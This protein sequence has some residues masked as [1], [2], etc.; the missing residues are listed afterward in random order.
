MRINAETSSDMKYFNVQP[1]VITL[2]EYLRKIVNEINKGYGAYV[3]LEKNEDRRFPNLDYRTSQN[4]SIVFET[5][6]NSFIFTMYMSTIINY[7]K[8]KLWIKTNIECQKDLTEKLNNLF[9]FFNTIAE[10]HQESEWK[11]DRNTFL[12]EFDNINMYI[13]SN[14]Y[15]L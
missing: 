12:S 2:R 1:E 6:N 10:E 5:Y 9:H 3:N 15:N 14:K 7:E 8:D 13:D 11:F 4:Y